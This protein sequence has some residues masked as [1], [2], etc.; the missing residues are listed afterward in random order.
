MGNSCIPNPMSSFRPKRFPSTISAHPFT[1]KIRPDSVVFKLI[2]FK[3]TDADE[4]D[5]LKKTVPQEKLEAHF[6][7]ELRQRYGISTA[8]LNE[9]YG[10]SDNYES[11]E[12]DA[13][14]PFPT[15]HVRSWD[16]KA[17]N[18]VLLHNQS[19]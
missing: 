6:E 3:K 18:D 1:A 11:V 4:V 5:E 15:L 10:S 17:K 14:L 19:G 2:G 16:F 12:E 8:D 9:R 7:S 13:P